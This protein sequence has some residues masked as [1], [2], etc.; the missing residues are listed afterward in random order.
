[1]ALRTEAIYEKALT[2]SGNVEDNFLDLAKSL[3]QLRDREPDLVKRIWEKTNLGSRK[4]Y[5]LMNIDEWYTGLPVGRAR[6]KAIGWTKLQIIGPHIN[7]EN[8]DELLDMA[9]NNTAAQLKVLMKGEKPVKDAHCVLM[10]LSARQ[11]KEFESVL[12][13]HGATRSGRGILNKEDALIAALRK[14]KD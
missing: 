10:Y 4:A 2:L 12:L 6:L 3:R 7:A 11:Y 14:V 1:M 13:S 5:Y 9:E 8:C